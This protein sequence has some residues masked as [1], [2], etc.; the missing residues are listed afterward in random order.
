MLK[1]MEVYMAVVNC[2]SSVSALLRCAADAKKN[3]AKYIATAKFETDDGD[4]YEIYTIFINKEILGLHTIN[5]AEVMD[6][7]PT[8]WLNDEV[9]PYVVSIERNSFK[10]NEV[11]YSNILEL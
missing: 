1:K 11:K 2:P 10:I 3:G 7:Q 5:V 9:L 8:H 6:D 4:D